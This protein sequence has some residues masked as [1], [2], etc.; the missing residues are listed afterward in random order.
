MFQKAAIPD[1]PNFWA[2]ALRISIASASPRF[3]SSNLKHPDRNCSYWNLVRHGKMN[4]QRI[5]YNL[6]ISKTPRNWR[7]TPQSFN[8]WVKVWMDQTNWTK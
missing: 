4:A 6:A 7:I 3:K 5:T 1:L 8:T 2:V